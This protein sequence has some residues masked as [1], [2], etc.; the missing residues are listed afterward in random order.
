MRAYN[1]GLGQSAQGDP[2]T[3]PLVRG[4]GDKGRPLEAESLLAFQRPMKAKK[5][6]PLTVFFCK[7]TVCDVSIQVFTTNKE[8]SLYDIFCF[9]RTMHFSAKHGIAIV[10]LSVCPSVC[11][12]V[13]Y[14]RAL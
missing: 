6:T 13:C 7:L 12:S 11:L 1:G 8:V 4:S 5:I 3:E 10:I 9:Y 14:V 2:G